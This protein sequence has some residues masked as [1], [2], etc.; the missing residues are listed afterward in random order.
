MGVSLIC[1][2][3]QLFRLTIDPLV[4]NGLSH[5]Y[6]L[7]ESAFILRG[8]WVNMTFSFHFSMKIILANR[9]AP[10]GTP[11][12]R[13]HILGYSVSIS[14][15][16]RTPGLYGLNGISMEICHFRID[17]LMDTFIHKLRTE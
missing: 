6:L 2:S 4:T 17:P 1:F 10:D 15:I 13:R 9:I 14:S 16:K 5:P 11:R 7:D 12:L 8:I 3:E